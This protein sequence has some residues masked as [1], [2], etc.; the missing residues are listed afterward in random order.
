[1][2]SFFFF[3]HKWKCPELLCP[4]LTSSHWQFQHILLKRMGS[5]WK[6]W[7]NLG[8]STGSLCCNRRDCCKSKAGANLSLKFG[9][10]LRAQAPPL[11]PGEQQLGQS[12]RAAAAPRLRSWLQHFRAAH[13]P[14]FA[15]QHW[16]RAPICYKAVPERGN[17]GLIAFFLRIYLGI[18]KPNLLLQP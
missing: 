5:Y 4:L 1:M 13:E 12:S 14:W 6:C 17:S 16:L 11:V 15:Q 2:C 7:F 9:H 3:Y 18:L 8:W 10:P